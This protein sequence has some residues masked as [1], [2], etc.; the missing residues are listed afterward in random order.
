MQPLPEHFTR[1][2]KG[3]FGQEGEHWLRHLPSTLEELS[4][5]WS[6]SLLPAFENLSYNYVAPTFRKDGTEAVLKIGVPN[7]ELN[8][9]IEALRLI[10]G[11]GVDP[12]M[13]VDNL[14]HS[15]FKG[16]DAQLEAAIAYLEEMIRKHPVDVPA[17]PPHPDKSFKYNSKKK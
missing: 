8:T 11:H 14:P 5:R 9:E 12:D 6:L 7:K 13:V 1:R 4:R 3:T 2:I 15:T 10:E 17:P 16:K